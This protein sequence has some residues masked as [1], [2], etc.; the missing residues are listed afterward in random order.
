MTQHRNMHSLLGDFN[1][2]VP[3]Y[4]QVGTRMKHILMFMFMFMFM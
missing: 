3:L 2:E 1:A 4:Q